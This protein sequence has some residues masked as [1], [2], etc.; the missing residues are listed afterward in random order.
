MSFESL[1][2]IVDSGIDKIG[3]PMPWYSILT[4][5]IIVGLIAWAM[6]RFVPCGEVD[7]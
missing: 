6:M 7:Q 3:Q 4:A 1:G 5:V 2:R